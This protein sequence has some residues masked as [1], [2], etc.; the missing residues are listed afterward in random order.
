MDYREWLDSTIRKTGGISKFARTVGVTTAS[1]I[2][3]RDGRSIPEWYRANRLAEVSGEPLDVI[4]RLLTE[5]HQARSEQR[6]QRP[7]NPYSIQSLRKPLAAAR[8]YP[9]QL[10]R[11]TTPAAL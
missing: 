5:A 4:Q 7:P 2:S 1:A 10:M 3:W 8:A 11:T 6:R 9:A